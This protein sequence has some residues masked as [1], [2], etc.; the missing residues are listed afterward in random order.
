MEDK[1]IAA[2]MD[3]S[4]KRDKYVSA[5]FDIAYSIEAVKK[6]IVKEKYLEPLE[7]LAKANGF[8]EFTPSF[9]KHQNDYFRNWNFVI[10]LKKK[11]WSFLKI[12][13]QYIE[14]G[15][16][17]CYGLQNVEEGDLEKSKLIKYMPKIEDEVKNEA[18]KFGYECHYDNG[19]EWYL[20]HKQKNTSFWENWTDTKKF[21][22]EIEMDKMENDFRNIIVEELSKIGDRLE[23]KLEEM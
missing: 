11:E 4:D 23:D 1:V 3:N 10:T 17:F 14:Y 22:T 21:F 12:A 19:N 15:K 9:G 7:K 8:E 5:A 16:G 20:L 6:Y 2:I 18:K 13:L